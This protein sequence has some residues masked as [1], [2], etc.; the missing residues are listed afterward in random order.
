MSTVVLY[1]AG[2]GRSGSTLLASI[3]GEVDGVFAAGEVRYLWQ[4]GL[5][6]SRL[7]GCGVPVRECPIWGKVLAQSGHLDE[8]GRGEGVVSLL[9]RTGRIRNLPAVLMG[10]FRPKF[11]PARSADTARDR[12]ALGDIYAAMAHVTGSR[13]IVDSSKLPAYANVLTATPGIDLRVVHLIRDPRGAAHSWSSR[14]ALSDGAARS[15]M[16]QIG[17][18]KSAFLWDIW[19]FSGGI[20][21]GR[22][23][24]RYMRLRYEDFI[25]DPRRAVRQIL[26]MVGMEDAELPFVSGTEALTSFNHSVAGNPDRLRHGLIRLRQDDRWR[27]GMARR[28]Q[29]LV[30]VLTL[31]LLMHYGYSVRP[32]KA[33]PASGETIFDR[34][35]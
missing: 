19:N 13:V 11:D 29:R 1:I 10:N 7:C 16:E 35:P 30:S 24:D 33:S 34:A 8:P 9:K 18:A 23:P 26:A 5:A 20:L 21:F 31:P 12:A 14:K 6:E 3:L 25:A 22:T 28:D 17:P 2:T 4:R 32:G 15:H 27:T